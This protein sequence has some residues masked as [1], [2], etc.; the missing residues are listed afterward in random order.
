MLDIRAVVGYLINGRML[1]QYYIFA[2]GESAEFIKLN[3]TKLNGLLNDILM[4]MGYRSER[5]IF[6]VSGD[7]CQIR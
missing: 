4:V 7:L 1:P 6:L 5:K 2:N 3:F